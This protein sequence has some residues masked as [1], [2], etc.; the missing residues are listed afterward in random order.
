MNRILMFAM[1]GAACGPTAPAQTTPR[2]TPLRSVGSADNLIEAHR[3]ESE[4]PAKCVGEE[5]WDVKV[6]TD[7]EAGNVPLSHARAMTIAELRALPKPAHVPDDL[8]RQDGTEHTAVKLTDVQ[9]IDYRI[10]GGDKGD[11]DFHRGY[12]W[13]TTR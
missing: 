12:R 13:G 7:D 4:T 11:Q 6:G 3:G 5:R 2:I 9:I 8:P 1:L 10:E